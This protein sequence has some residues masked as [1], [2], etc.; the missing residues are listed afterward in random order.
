MLFWEVSFLDQSGKDTITYKFSEKSY[1]TDIVT[2]PFQLNTPD[3]HMLMKTVY[4]VQ[5]NRRKVDD[6]LVYLDA[7]TTVLD[8]EPAYLYFT[9]VVNTPAMLRDYIRRALSSGLYFASIR[10]RQIR[11]NRKNV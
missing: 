10:T 5:D 4:Y 1:K 3:H 7:V 2:E 9:R 8:K 6:T 11:E